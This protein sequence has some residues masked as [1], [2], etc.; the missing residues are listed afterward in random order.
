MIMGF[1]DM[2]ALPVPPEGGGQTAA[3]LTD[4]ALVSAM[5]LAWNNLAAS[6]PWV[7]PKTEDK[8]SSHQKTHCG[9]HR[10][11][12]GRLGLGVLSQWDIY[13]SENE[14]RLQR[15]FDAEIMSSGF[16]V[17]MANRAVDLNRSGV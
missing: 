10:D 4:D 14:R 13:L 9:K 11:A 2:P 5:R 17:W 1:F 7:K 3:P 6:S 16:A 8:I 15:E 12:A